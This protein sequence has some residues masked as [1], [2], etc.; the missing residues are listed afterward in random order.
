MTTEQR[1]IEPSYNS[2]CHGPHSYRIL[3]LILILMLPCPALDV[4]TS[5]L[6]QSVHVC[7]GRCFTW[8][9]SPMNPY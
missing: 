5:S 9:A 8:P 1:Y 2:K 7:T 6:V 4:I 3:M